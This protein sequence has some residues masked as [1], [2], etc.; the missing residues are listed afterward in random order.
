VGAHRVT[1][2]W[3]RGPRRHL[4]WIATAASVLLLTAAVSFATRPVGSG[5]A[6]DPT[7]AGGR[8]GMAL[9]AVSDVSASSTASTGYQQSPDPSLS[10]P[11]AQ[12]ETSPSGHAGSSRPAEQPGPSAPRRSAATS[13]SA[14][15]PQTSAPTQGGG[16]LAEYT[17]SSAWQSGYVASVVIRNTA[18]TASAW[19]LEIRLPSGA[20]VDQSW[21]ATFAISGAAATGLTMRVTPAYTPTLAADASIT[22]GY[23]VA[24]TT[25]NNQP[26]S[27]AVNSHPCQ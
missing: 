22:I 5:R 14:R 10:S 19:T 26:V 4:V 6:A 13:A 11:S 17:V 15:S 24:R 8:S 12:P 7:Q 16:L 9:P 18:K 23:I 20:T 2:D 25:T 21:N 3:W 27:C 1:P